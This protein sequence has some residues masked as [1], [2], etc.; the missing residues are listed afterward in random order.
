MQTQANQTIQRI[1]E[2]GPISPPRQLFTLKKFADRNNGFL[3]L[4]AI[5]NQVFKAQPR[6]SSK[7]EVP[8]NGMLDHHVIV[9]VGRTVLIDEAAYFQW[10]DA[11]QE[12]GQ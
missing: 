3:T 2:S 6:H 9:R 12:G 5:T 11:Q 7:G 10:L 1:T 4:S 8:G